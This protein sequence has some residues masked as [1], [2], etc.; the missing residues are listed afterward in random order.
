MNKTKIIHLDTLIWDIQAEMLRRLVAEHKGNCDGN[1][2]I[3]LNC[4]FPLYE[5]LIGRPAKEEEQRLF[6]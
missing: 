1:C 4:L 6:I 5:K 2:T 3:S